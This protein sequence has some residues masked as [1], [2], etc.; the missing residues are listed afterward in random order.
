MFI[1]DFLHACFQREYESHCLYLWG[2]TLY[3]K[4]KELNMFGL[5]IYWLRTAH[6]KIVMDA[7]NAWKYFIYFHLMII[8]KFL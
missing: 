8:A 3:M 4:Y 6:K 1:N 2:G 5:H 7:C